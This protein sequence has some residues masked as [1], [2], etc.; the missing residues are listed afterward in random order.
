MRHFNL[1]TDNSE[2]IPKVNSMD[3]LDTGGWPY[4]LELNGEDICEGDAD[5]II[6]AKKNTVI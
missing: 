3:L 5:V 2:K 6:Y 4:R 1:Q